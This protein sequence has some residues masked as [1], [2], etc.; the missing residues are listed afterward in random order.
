M[1]PL[2]S[3]KTGTVRRKF[4]RRQSRKTASISGPARGPKFPTWVITKESFTLWLFEKSRKSNPKNGFIF[5][6]ENVSR[7]W[8]NLE[9]KLKKASPKP[10]LGPYLTQVG[11]ALKWAK[12]LRHEAA[13]KSRD[14]LWLNLD[15]TSVPVVMLKQ[16]GTMKKMSKKIAWRFATKYKANMEET[17]MCFTLVGVICSDPNIQPLLPQVIFLSGKHATWAFMEEVWPNLPQNVYVQ[18][19]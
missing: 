5:E 17:R 6:A 14:V 3:E 15:E 9:K 11:V 16:R 1:K 19:K 8:K 12:Y 13:R 10:H 2:G 18:R 7:K 4:R